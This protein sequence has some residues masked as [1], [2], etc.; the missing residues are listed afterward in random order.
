[1][2]LLLI[3][4]IVIIGLLIAAILDTNKSA[5]KKQ[6]LGYD[7]SS[8]S[9]NKYVRQPGVFGLYGFHHWVDKNGEPL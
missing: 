1:M 9:G 5:P 4:F 2:I 7:Y 8:H 3:V 6:S